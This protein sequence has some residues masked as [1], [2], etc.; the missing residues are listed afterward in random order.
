[1]LVRKDSKIVVEGTYADAKKDVVSNLYN[2]NFKEGLEL[3]KESELLLEMFLNYL[4]SGKSNT[5]EEKIKFNEAC[6]R[7]GINHPDDIPNK[8]HSDMDRAVELLK[9]HG[10][11]LFSDATA[12]MRLYHF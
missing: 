6:K 8:I 1:M 7:H 2:S 10:K 11:S 12:L 4:T 3:I 9:D 5:I